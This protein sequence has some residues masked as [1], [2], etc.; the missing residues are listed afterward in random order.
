M[1]ASHVAGGIA[2]IREAIPS[3]TADEIENALA[4]SGVPVFDARNGITRPRIQVPEAITFLETNGPPPGGGNGGTTPAATTIS[5]DGGGGTCGLVGIEP[6]LVL[7]LVRLGSGRRFAE[8]Q[9]A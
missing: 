7:G 4:L 9:K 8:R 6:F 2:A 1:A 5:G 3:A